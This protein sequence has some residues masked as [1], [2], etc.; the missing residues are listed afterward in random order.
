MPTFRRFAPTASRLR[1]TMWVTALL[2]GLAACTPPPDAPTEKPTEPRAA[3]T[4]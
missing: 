3:P 2:L 1:L 4:R